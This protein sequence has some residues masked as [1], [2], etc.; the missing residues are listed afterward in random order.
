ML[1]AFRYSVIII[2]RDFASTIFVI[3]IFKHLHLFSN[4]NF[5]RFLCPLRI[6]AHLVLQVFKY[7]TIKTQDGFI[8]EYPQ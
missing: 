2:F 3:E 8:W 5:K 1:V 4:L 6:S 7:L